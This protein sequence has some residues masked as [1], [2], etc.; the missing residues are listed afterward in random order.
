MRTATQA[1]AQ[2]LGDL[3]AATHDHHVDILRRPLKKEVTDIPTH[4][5]GFYAHLIGNISD[6]MKEV[7]V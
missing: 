2:R 3:D 7:R 4:D 1:V 6:K 5:I